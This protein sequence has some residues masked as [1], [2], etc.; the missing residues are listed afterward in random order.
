MESVGEGPGHGQHLVQGEAG[1]GDDGG[2]G[3]ESGEEMKPALLLAVSQPG[4]D[5]GGGGD[6]VGQADGEPEES[7]VTTPPVTRLDQ[8]G[9]SPYHH[10]Q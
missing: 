1:H 9:K 10:L 4:D 7:R 5:D 6:D 3:G 2:V 8:Q